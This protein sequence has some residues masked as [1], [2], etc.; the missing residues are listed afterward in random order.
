MV[1]LSRDEAKAFNLLK[2]KKPGDPL[3]VIDDSGKPRDVVLVRR[4]RQNTRVKAIDNDELLL[5]PLGNIL[6]TS[7]EMALPDQP[8][9]SGS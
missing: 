1:S 2:R 9:T 4:G 3:K 5:V 8:D 6:L 7:E